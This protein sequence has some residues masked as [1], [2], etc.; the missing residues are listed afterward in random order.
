MKRIRKQRQNIHAFILI[1][2]NRVIGHWYEEGNKTNK[3]QQQKAP[4]NTSQRSASFIF[5]CYQ[6]HWTER[7]LSVYSPDFCCT[8]SRLNSTNCIGKWTF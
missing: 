4:Q 5:Q 7:T 2:N 8:H 3:P 6:C 1:C